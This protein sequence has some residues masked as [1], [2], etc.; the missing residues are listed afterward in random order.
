MTSQEPTL[1]EAATAQSSSRKL[2]K[3]NTNEAVNRLLTEHFR[4]FSAEDI[5][6]VTRDGQT[7]R[8]ALQSVRRAATERNGRVSTRA[9]ADIRKKYAPAASPHAQLVVANR[10]E[11]VNHELAAA[12]DLAVTPNC[13]KRTRVPLS[14][15]LSSCAHLNQRELVGVFRFCLDVK[16][17]LKRVNLTFNVEVMQAVRRM[18]LDTRFPT[19]CSAMRAHWDETLCLQFAHMSREAISISDWWKAYGSV[20]GLVMNHG[21]AE[22]VMN[23]KGS[24]LAIA[25][26]LNELTS[27]SKL[28]M[29][30]FGAAVSR[31]A[32][33]QIE[34]LIEQHIENADVKDAPW[35][36]KRVS[37]IIA[38]VLV[39][40]K[41]IVGA[42]SLLRVRLVDVRFQEIT[43][44]VDVPS[45]EA[46]VRMCIAAKI[47][48]VAYAVQLDPLPFE[49]II[50]QAGSDPQVRVDECVIELYSE[51]RRM[52][53]EFLSQE[54][55]TTGD[56]LAGIVAAK[57][58]A[59]RHV[60]ATIILEAELAKAVAGPAGD[61]E[62]ERLLLA[63]LPT[64]EDGC[65]V[66]DSLEAVNSLRGHVWWKCMS[67]ASHG[68]ASML[69]DMLR[70]MLGGFAPW[71]GNSPGTTDFMKQV[72][73]KLP[74]FIRATCESGDK[75]VELTGAMALRQKLAKVLKAERSDN[76][77]MLKDL[78]L[79][80]VFRWMLSA[81]ETEAVDG[82]LKK[83]MAKVDSMSAMPAS[84]GAE[85]APSSSAGDPAA[86]RRKTATTSAPASS[87]SFF[88]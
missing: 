20:C 7:L 22:K 64:A 31:V 32:S 6:G 66:A 21:K 50:G 78:E 12:F 53:A 4:T 86:K 72:A 51:A 88:E 83:A 36:E 76:M 87:S 80:V 1:V 9:I 28:G 8:Q 35:T 57:A 29:K 48:T 82:L 79:F 33:E 46:H 13:Q 3:V 58:A 16:P 15:Y 11:A 74:F 43:V 81:R 34:H 69:E 37:T 52:L 40:A 38:S 54:T 73:T 62:V 67:G 77:V 17:A 60:D 70:R 2:R 47:K 18:S 24:W 41:K 65:T 42:E 84:V 23:A 49:N 19:E 30:M 56:Q 55:W 85:G 25:D 71:A 27:M 75:V 14:V 10:A 44:Q 5:D 59:L 61:S 63:A 26:E 39:G 68:R 45:V